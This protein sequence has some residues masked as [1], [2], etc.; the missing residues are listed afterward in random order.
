MHGYIKWQRR[1]S[2]PGEDWVRWWQ[3]VKEHKLTPLCECLHAVA[4]NETRGHTSR[5]TSMIFISRCFSVW[6]FINKTSGY[7]FWDSDSLLDCAPSSPLCSVKHQSVDVAAGHL[8]SS[9]PGYMRSR[10]AQMS[11]SPRHVLQLLLGDPAAVSSWMYNLSSVLWVCPGVSSTV[12]RARNSSPGRHPGGIPI[13]CLNSLMPSLLPKLPRSPSHFSVCLSFSCSPHP[14][15]A[16][17]PFKS[18]EAKTQRTL[19]NKKQ[20]KEK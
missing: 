12:G 5:N 7:S 10:A 1:W 11:F 3:T 6:L 8:S 13:G 18:W 19:E 17:S 15:Y 9:V 2:K 14:C 20:D 16:L 4:K